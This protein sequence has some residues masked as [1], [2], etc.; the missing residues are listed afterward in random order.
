[1]ESRYRYNLL[2]IRNDNIFLCW[3]TD[4][5]ESDSQQYSGCP[6]SVSGVC[7]WI[8]VKKTSRGIQAHISG[9]WIW[10]SSHL[11]QDVE[12]KMTIIHRFCILEIWYS[13]A[14]KIWRFQ[15]SDVRIWE[16]QRWTYCKLLY[17]KILNKDVGWYWFV[18]VWPIWYYDLI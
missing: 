9:F 3:K 8:T 11:D 13:T 1:M 15:N 4:H 16:F 7:V 10:L 14:L 2:R 5:I 6:V 17:T 18:H 12:T